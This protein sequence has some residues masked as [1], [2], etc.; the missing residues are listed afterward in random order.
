MAWIHTGGSTS[1]VSGELS[2]AQSPELI[3][4]P[5][6]MGITPNQQVGTILVA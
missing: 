6:G 4:Y 2:E 3:L 5:V 1:R